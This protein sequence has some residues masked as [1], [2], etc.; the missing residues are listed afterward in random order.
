MLQ[1]P[2]LR[3][4]AQ[5][6]PFQSCISRIGNRHH[7]YLL[8]IGIRENKLVPQAPTSINNTVCP[9]R[10]DAEA[11]KLDRNSPEE[12]LTKAVG[13]EY[14]ANKSEL[15]QFHASTMLLFWTS[16]L[17]TSMYGPRTDPASLPMKPKSVWT[18]YKSKLALGQ[19]IDDLNISIRFQA[20]SPCL[21]L[22][23]C[24]KAPEMPRT[25]GFRAVQK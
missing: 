14:I 24:F 22:N 8:G 6:Y 11:T 3:I 1:I 5:K 17:K 16:H 21:S 2:S 18:S 25:Q 20:V 19:L 10:W 12:R 13:V 4:T 15:F 23:K 9:H 7:W